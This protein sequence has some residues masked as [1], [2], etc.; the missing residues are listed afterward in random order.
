METQNQKVGHSSLAIQSARDTIVSQGI[1]P[2]LM[3]EI[4]EAI[5]RQLPGYAAIAREI[6][7]ARL[8]DFKNAILREIA[9]TEAVNPEAFKD[10]DFQYTLNRAQHAYA[11]SGN[12]EIGEILVDLIA[13]RSKIGT[14]DRRLLTLDA[15]VETAGTLTNNEFAELWMIFFLRYTSIV[16]TAA[17]IEWVS[18]YLERHLN[19]F[20]EEISRELPS[21][22]Y[23]EA[24][25]C[26]TMSA[27]RWSLSDIVST[28][29][30]GAFSAGFTLKDIELSLEGE[31][32]ITVIK[33][34]TR[35]CFNNPEKVQFDVAN[36]AELTERLLSLPISK[37]AGA[38]ACMFSDL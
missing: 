20:L 2:D 22:L 37:P 14:R 25:Q 28:K 31:A 35:Q 1:T 18:R 8:A 34:L 6:V 12:K 27:S 21:Y 15:A 32:N 16:G 3:A 38:P 5:G 24:Q 11:R 29:Y 23:I 10:P 7:D 33:P 17:D 9:Q 30:G 19:P 36:E 4:I 26:G 13:R